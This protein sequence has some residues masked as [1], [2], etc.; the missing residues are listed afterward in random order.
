MKPIIFFLIILSFVFISLNCEREDLYTFMEESTKPEKV[1]LFSDSS[2]RN[3]NLGG[4]SGAD[5]ICQS[6]YNSGFSGD[7]PALNVKAL[8]SVNTSDNVKNLLPSKW[9]DIPVVGIH[10]STK[11]ETLLKSSWGELWSSPGILATLQTA[12][13][14]STPHWTGSDS[15]GL[16]STQVCLGWTSSSNV[17]V[18]Y[19][20]SQNGISTNWMY[21]NNTSC[22]TLSAIVCMAY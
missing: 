8:I 18:G 12:T 16:A 21:Q 14:L 11:A 2:T 19:T 6:L 13:G 17:E 10:F 9:W 3:G 1:Y 15:N 7:F 4:R 20:G 22:D 5:S